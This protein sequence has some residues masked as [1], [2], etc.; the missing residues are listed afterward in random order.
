MEQELYELLASQVTFNRYT[1]EDTYGNNTYGSNEVAS[2]RIDSVDNRFGM[3]TSQDQQPSA[4]V[5]EYTLITDITP[6]LFA[7]RDKATL[8]DGAITFVRNVRV[9]YDEVGPHHVVMT[10]STEDE[11]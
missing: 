11:S 3:A 9:E 4:T 5:Q 1:S 6:T 7:V 8:P 2:C 10:V